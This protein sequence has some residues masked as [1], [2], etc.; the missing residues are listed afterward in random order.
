MVPTIYMQLDEMPLT[1]NGKVNTKALPDPEIEGEEFV[2]PEGETESLVA[3]EVCKLLGTKQISA[4]ANLIS[5]GMT[6][7]SLMNLALQLTKATGKKVNVADVMQDPTVRGTA[8]MLDA[9]KTGKAL[10]IDYSV[11][12]YY[13]ITE[14]QRGLIIDW[15]MNHGS[16]QYNIPEVQIFHNVSGEML[17][18]AVIKMVEA[19]PYLKTRLAMKDGDYMQVR[20]EDAPVEV[21][22]QKVDKAPDGSFFKSRVRPFDLFNEN[23]YRFEIYDTGDTSYF[24]YDFHHTIY[25]GVSSAYLLEYLNATL[26]GEELEKEEY[27]YF[28]H[29][30]EE[31]AELDSEEAVKEAE[32]Y[33]DTLLSGTDATVYPHSTAPDDKNGSKLLKMA[34]KEFYAG[35]IRKYCLDNGI[36]PNNY[37]ST[38]LSILLHRVTREETVCFSTINNGRNDARKM[39]LMGMFVKTIPMVST[40]TNDSL[41]STTMKAEAAKTQQEMAGILAHD[42]Y[43]FTKMVERY[44]LKFEILFD[45]QDLVN[46]LYEFDKETGEINDCLKLDNVMVPLCLTVADNGTDTC[47]CNIEYDASLYSNKDMQMLAEMYA[48]L[49]VS[50]AKTEKIADAEMVDESEKQAI[51]TLSEGQR[52]EYDYEDTFITMFLE[53]VKEIPQNTAVVDNAGSYTY[54]ELNSLS[55]ALA[56]EILGIIDTKKKAEKPFIS[57]MMGIQKEFLI[58]TI[59]VERAGMAYVPLDHDYPDDRLQYMLEDSE[60]QLLITTHKEFDEKKFAKNMT[61]NASDGT[62]L[63]SPFSIIHSPLNTLFIDDFLANIKTDENAENINLATPDALAYMIYT[64]G[65]T[66]KP[67]G[68]MIPNRAKA[69]FVHFIREEWRLTEKSRICCHSSFS[70]DAS[71]EDLYPVL[72]AGGTLYVVPAEA[73]KDLDLLYKFIVDNGITGGCYTTQLGQML[74]QN[75]DLPVEY[76]VVGGE[77]MTANPD[78]KGRLINTYGPTEFTVDATFF[79]TEKG[80]EYT[81]IPIGRP[82]TSCLLARWV[83]SAWQE[84]RWQR[85]TGTA[86]T[87]RRKCSARHHS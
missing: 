25:D 48:T 14:N 57:I 72:T 32:T 16:T 67:K 71:I 1:P 76:L 34:S 2:E 38:V 49:A 84:G 66:G 74:L 33:F 20:C 70:F 82:L 45:Y 80:K 12:E 61:G 5:H 8:A 51:I 24:F 15:E 37:F 11:R 22:V 19:H 44:R 75:Y 47:Q 73:R 54:K 36:T 3:A 60:S 52:Q 77:K 29:S 6:S 46:L 69:N 56:K 85:D 65:S 17:K 35:A 9:K 55:N 21:S 59:A 83:S 28:E 43:P 68:V 81:N 42:Y 10:E 4:T 63:N 78:F 7:L 86:K 79:V 62:S 18:Q 64:S 39:S 41:T 58:A 53:H 40:I 23:L 13:P 27:T 50:L 30:L 31:K 26:K 87:S